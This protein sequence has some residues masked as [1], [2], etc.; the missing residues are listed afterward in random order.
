MSLNLSSGG[1]HAYFR[2]IIG[3][4]MTAINV[5]TDPTLCFYRNHWVTGRVIPNSHKYPSGAI[6]LQYLSLLVFCLPYYHPSS[7]TGFSEWATGSA[8]WPRPVSPARRL[9][10]VSL[11]PKL[12]TQSMQSYRSGTFFPTHSDHKGHIQYPLHH[13]PP[14]AEEWLGFC[15]HL[16][17]TAADQKPLSR[18]V[19]RKHISIQTNF[20]KGKE[21]C[22]EYH[23][24]CF[25]EWNLELHCPSRKR[26]IK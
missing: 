3:P 2:H 7:V 19:G 9:Y 4:Q 25:E 26:T 17:T 23:V 11:F 8:L 6:P 14:T 1:K 22:Y 10:I 24:F 13:P 21:N 5:K 16:Y 15:N 12:S 18:Q 20:R